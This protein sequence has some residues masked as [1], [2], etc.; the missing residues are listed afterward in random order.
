MGSGAK[1]GGQAYFPP[2][3]AGNAAGARAP[4]PRWKAERP[5]RQGA[6]KAAFFHTV[7][8]KITAVLVSLAVAGGVFGTAYS[9]A[10]RDEAPARARNQGAEEA[11]KRARRSGK[12]TGSRAGAAEPEEPEVGK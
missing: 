1:P 12:R 2:F 6:A 4:Q 8:G 11:Q 3:R 5:S 10:N 7:A 9:I